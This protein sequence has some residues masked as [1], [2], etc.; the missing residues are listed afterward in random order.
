VKS[1]HISGEIMELHHSKHHETYVNALNDVL[2]KLAPPGKAA[3]SGPSSGWRRLWRSPRRARQPLDLLA[4]P[5]PRR[6]RQ[7]SHRPHRWRD[8]R[9]SASRR[10]RPRRQH[11]LR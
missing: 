1:P 8:H 4:E 10:H 6:R 9:C 2:D 11:R 5:L 7:A 3:T